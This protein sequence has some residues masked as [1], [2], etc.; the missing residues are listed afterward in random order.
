VDVVLDGKRNAW[1]RVGFWFVLALAGMGIAAGA[2]TYG[3]SLYASG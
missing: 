3:L 2:V 1:W